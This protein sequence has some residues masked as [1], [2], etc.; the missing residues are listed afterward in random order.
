MNNIMGWGRAPGGR[1]PLFRCPNLTYTRTSEAPHERNR[2]RRGRL[3]NGNR[4]GDY[5]AAPRCGAKTRTGCACRQPAMANG[6]CRLHGGKSTGA[7]TPEGRRRARTARLLHGRRTAAVIG[8]RSA[9][10]AVNRRLAWMSELARELS[11]GHGA[12]RSDSCPPLG[13]HRRLGSPA[14]GRASRRARAPVRPPVNQNLA[15]DFFRSTSGCLRDIWNLISS[16]RAI[17]SRS[18][19]LSG[20]LMVG[21]TTTQPLTLRSKTAAL[22]SS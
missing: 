5:L 19:W 20:S 10:A 13:S 15:Y 21:G 16:S 12:H 22:P 8:L 2:R 3:K 6:R 9:A 18:C 11:A 17:M 7:R 1:R 14:V 4:S